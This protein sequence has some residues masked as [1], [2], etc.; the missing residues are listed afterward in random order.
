MQPEG[1]GSALTSFIKEWLLAATITLA[2][3]TPDYMTIPPE[4][5]RLLTA[6]R[7]LAKEAGVD[8]RY[9][10]DFSRLYRFY[11]EM[12][13]PMPD[14]QQAEPTLRAEQTSREDF[15]T[16]V[17]SPELR[18]HF[19]RAT[20]ARDRYA[21]RMEYYL[22]LKSFY[23]AFIFPLEQDVSI[24][25]S[26]QVLG[27]NAIAFTGGKE[28]TPAQLAVMRSGE[29]QSLLTAMRGTFEAIGR[30]SFPDNF[31][32]SDFTNDNPDQI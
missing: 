17:A 19:D 21:Q 20:S 6:I 32:V 18:A 29:T 30:I 10:S 5:K 9:V 27:V 7:R 16:V 26:C 11:L 4:I 3:A 8:P 22:L 25:R 1:Q 23:N 13:G 15:R 24:A 12:E 31:N 2:A 14:E 28:I